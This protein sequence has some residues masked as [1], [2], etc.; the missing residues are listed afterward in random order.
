M[1]AQ[2]QRRNVL[3]QLLTMTGP[4]A[5]LLSLGLGMFTMVGLPLTHEYLK[6]NGRRGR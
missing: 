3:T 2:T 4:L 6:R 5:D 1:A